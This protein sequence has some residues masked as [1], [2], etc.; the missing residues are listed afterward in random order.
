VVDA[1]ALHEDDLAQVRQLALLLGDLGELGGVLDEHDGGL[2]VVDDVLHLAG[3]AG[4]VDARRGAAGGL[5]AE[6][7]GGPLEAVVAEDAGGVAGLDAEG[8]QGAGDATD[9]L[10]VAAPRERLPGAVF[11]GVGGGFVGVGLA[12]GEEAGGDG[13]CGHELPAFWVRGGIT[14]RADARRGLS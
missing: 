9:Q 2:G 14:S 6:G 10:G 5:G 1:G 7:E 13:V 3:R 12:L 4:G 11:A 8:D